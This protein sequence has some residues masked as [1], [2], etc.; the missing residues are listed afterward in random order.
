MQHIDLGE[1]QYVIINDNWEENSSRLRKNPNFCNSVID[2]LL[3]KVVA[4]NW[5]TRSNKNNISSVVSN[6]YFL[7]Y[8]YF[9]FYSSALLKLNSNL[10]SCLVWCIYSIANIFMTTLC[11]GIWLTL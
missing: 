1:T 2:I 3:K 11:L 6:H 9:L 10:H 7:V 4:L 5:S 8:I